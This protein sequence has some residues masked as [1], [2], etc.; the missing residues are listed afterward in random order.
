[1]YVICCRANFPILYRN[2]WSAL[3]SA[4]NKSLESAGGRNGT[5]FKIWISASNVMSVLT[6]II[7]RVEHRINHQAYIKVR[8]GSITRKDV[9]VIQLLL[10]F[11]CVMQSLPMAHILHTTSTVT[12][13]HTACNATRLIFLYQKVLKMTSFSCQRSLATFEHII[14]HS[15]NFSCRNC[16]NKTSHTCTVYS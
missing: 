12:A 9:Y 11:S 3:E 7:K 1:M 4:I 10:G 2:L 16:W 14:K 13:S 8:S 5:K 6:S 15:T